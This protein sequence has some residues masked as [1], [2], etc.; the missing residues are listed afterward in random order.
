MF[1]IQGKIEGL[2]EVL[3]R[4]D[5]VEKKTK[6]KI[7]RKAVGQAGKILL[8]A[9]KQRAQK[10]SGLLR[11]SLGRKVKVYRNSGV[12]VAIVGPRTGYRQEVSRDGRKPVMSDPIRYA[13]LVELGTSHSAAFP[14]L[15]P[16]IEENAER[17]KDA[18]AGVIADGIAKAAGG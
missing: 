7:L 2:G 5:G 13:H 3:A 15:T 8:K 6:K 9:A 11:K 14:F 10:K 17:I 16:A 18:M 12:A 4:L 1:K